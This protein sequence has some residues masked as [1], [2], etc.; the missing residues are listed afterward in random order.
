LVWNTHSE[1][2][3]DLGNMR[4]SRPSPTIVTSSG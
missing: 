3:S 4:W 2:G 1:R